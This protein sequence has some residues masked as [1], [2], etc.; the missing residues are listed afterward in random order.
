MR[1]TPD[2]AQL[3]RCSSEPCLETDLDQASKS[4]RGLDH[5]LHK[6]CGEFLDE[7]AVSVLRTCRRAASVHMQA[8]TP[9]VDV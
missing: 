4:D 8:L 2:K 6:A 5:G 3:S 1:A 7:V 9:R